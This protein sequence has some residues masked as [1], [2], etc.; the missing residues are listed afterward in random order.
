[1]TWLETQLMQHRFT[2]VDY[3]FS[4]TFS[5]GFKFYDIGGTRVTAL[6]V[7]V[8]PVENA[9]ISLFTGVEPATPDLAF[10]AGLEYDFFT[11]KDNLFTGMGIFVDWLATDGGLFDVAS[12]GALTFGLKTKIGI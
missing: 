12:G 10:G 2:G 9:Y 5:G 4:N 3:N 6:N 11:K 7:T 8:S 1:M